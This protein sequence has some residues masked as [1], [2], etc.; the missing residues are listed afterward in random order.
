MTA[1]DRLFL[2]EHGFNRQRKAELRRQTAERALELHRKRVEWPAISK[3]LG[4]DPAN[5]RHAVRHFFPEV[6]L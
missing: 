6:E 5:L 2:K 3:R 4:M 1:T